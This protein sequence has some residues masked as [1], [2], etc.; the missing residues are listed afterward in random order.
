[1]AKTVKNKKSDQHI[2]EK[3]YSI[4][5]SPIITEKSTMASQYNKITFSVAIDANKALIKEAVEKLFN[6]KV[7]NVNTIVQKGKLKSF[8][9]IKALRS[10]KKKAIVTLA[11]GQ[12]VDVTTKV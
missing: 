12:T 9:G 7:V 3:I 6:V 2:S 10:D 4:I 8:R 5:R 11:E 1:M